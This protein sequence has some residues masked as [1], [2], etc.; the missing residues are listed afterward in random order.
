MTDVHDTEHALYRDGEL[1]QPEVCPGRLARGRYNREAA[2]KGR[3][4]GWLA[5]TAGVCAIVL[6][7]LA[8]WS[9]TP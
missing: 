9:L 1:G 5:D 3:I 8:F 2:V 6:L 4:R 7:F